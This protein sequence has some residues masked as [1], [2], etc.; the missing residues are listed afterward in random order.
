MSPEGSQALGYIKKDLDAV[1][2]NIIRGITTPLEAWQALE[3]DFNLTN[4]PKKEI[5]ACEL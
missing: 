4:E 2:M 5:Y 3:L 1:G